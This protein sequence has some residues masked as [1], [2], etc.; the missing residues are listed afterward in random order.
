MLAQGPPDLNP[1]MREEPARPL[2]GNWRGVLR[3]ALE[4]QLPRKR[5]GGAGQHGPALQTAGHTFPEPGLWTV[6]WGLG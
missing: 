6:Q 1:D 4:E 3:G 5:S 2:A